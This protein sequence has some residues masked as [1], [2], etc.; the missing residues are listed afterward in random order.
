MKELEKFI[1]LTEK[2]KSDMNKNVMPVQGS[3]KSRLKDF[4]IEVFKS[5]VVYKS[6]NIGSD[7]SDRKG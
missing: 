1:Q 3:V 4:E 5:L 7:R 6:L 2:Y